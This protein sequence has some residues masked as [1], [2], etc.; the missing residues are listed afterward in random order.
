MLSQISRL[1]A[2]VNSHSQR[3]FRADLDQHN[4]IIQTQGAFQHSV[5]HYLHAPYN[6]L[7]TSKY[8]NSNMCMLCH[9]SRCDCYPNAYSWYCKR[10]SGSSSE[11]LKA[12]HV[13]L[14]AYIVG[15]TAVESVKSGQ[16]TS[17]VGSN[18]S[19]D[20]INQSLIGQ[21]D[22]SP[23][24]CHLAILLLVCNSYSCPAKCHRT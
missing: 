13:G 4:G 9:H 6:V 11:R 19:V 1:Q 16:L 21:R 20:E 2:Y 15:V 22:D 5:E 7:T 10:E 8:N 24:R 12:L 3:N 17:V 18:G 14:R 23:Q